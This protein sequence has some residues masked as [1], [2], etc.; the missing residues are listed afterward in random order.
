MKRTALLIV[1][2]AVTTVADDNT[3]ATKIARYG[4]LGLNDDNSIGNATLIDSFLGIEAT[5]VRCSSP[6]SAYCCWVP[7][8]RYCY[9]NGRCWCI[10]K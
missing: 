1:A 9:F 8:T 10:S 6:C 5:C 3:L 4:D 2:I 7:P